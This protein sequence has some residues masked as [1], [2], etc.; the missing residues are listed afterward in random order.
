MKNIYLVLHNQA[1]LTSKQ[2]DSLFYTPP[3]KLVPTSTGLNSESKINYQNISWELLKK[4]LNGLINKANTINLRS[5]LPEIFKVNIVR[6]RGIFCRSLMKSQ[7]ISPNFT[8]VYAAIVSVI[9]T[10]FPEIGL[11]ILKRLILHFRKSYKR[12]DKSSCLCVG[13]FIAHLINQGVVHELLALEILMLLLDQPSSDSVEIAVSM[14]KDVGATINESSPQGL[15]AVFERFRGILHEGIVE[16][17]VEFTIEG[18]FKIRRVGFDKSGFPKKSEG[19]DLVEESDKITHEISIDDVIEAETELDVF[20]YDP[21]HEEHEKQYESYKKEIL[22]IEQDD[23]TE[24]KIT[25]EKNKA[26]IRGDIENQNKEISNVKDMTE[27]DV[28]NLRRVIYLT[29]MSSLDFEEAGHKLLKIVINPG[30]EIELVI[31]II[32]C[33][34]QERTYI[35]YF[36]LLAQR[37]CYL[38]R[39]YQEIFEHCFVKQCMLVHRLEMNKLRNVSKLFAH[40]LSTDAISWEVLQCIRLTMEDTSSSGRI[41]IKILFQELA[42]NI[43]LKKIN[44][45]IHN[46]A[47]AHWFAGIFPRD[48]ATNVRFS[49][50]FFTSIGLGGLTD[51]QREYLN[52]LPHILAGNHVD[53]LAPVS[54]HKVSGAKV[55]MSSTSTYFTSLSD[56]SHTSDSNSSS[57]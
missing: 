32:E 23:E 2:S 6:G 1:V 34:S 26:Y 4:A 29:I 31:M 27:T 8:P 12:N 9:N 56:S 44:E 25:D 15:R 17:R 46:P 7:T 38:S 50:N 37:F 47:F 40:L 13:Q 30:Q 20:S 24:N 33:C 10:K 16:K 36:G 41:F 14:T 39:V 28:V 55:D 43:G 21:I 11:L 52:H 35:K 19:L 57:E 53:Q 3:F 18:L 45:R 51:G 22:A 5:I 54:A 48:T 42:E 49:I